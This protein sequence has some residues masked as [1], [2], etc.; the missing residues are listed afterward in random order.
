MPVTI[1]LSDGGPHV[2]VESAVEELLRGVGIVIVDR[3]PPVIGSWFR[4][5][6]AGAARTVHSDAARE[7]ALTARHMADTRLILAQDA[8]VTATPMQNLAP[9]PASLQPTEDAVLRIGAL[10]IVKLNWTVVV[11]PLSPAQQAVLDRRPQLL[12]SPHE[13]AAVLDLLAP[14]PP[15]PPAS[16]AQPAAREGLREAAIGPVQG[17]VRAPGAEL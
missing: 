8:T 14:A 6:R 10:L 1:H 17:T 16:S 3:E 5:M 4:R 7:A 13:V 2:E 11:H 9:L 15:G 12:T